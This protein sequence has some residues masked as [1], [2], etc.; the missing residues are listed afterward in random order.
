M[1]EADRA[2]VIRDLIG[3]RPDLPGLLDRERERVKVKRGALAAGGYESMAGDPDLYKYF[4]RRYQ[5]LTRVSGSIGVVLPRGAFINH[6]SRGFRE[7]LFEETTTRRVDF[8]LNKARWAFD[9]E[10][11]YSVALVVAK[12]DEPPQD[13]RVEIAGVAS[14][15]DEWVRQSMTPG[16]CISSAGFGPGWM[17]PLVR[18]QAEADLLAKVR[19]GNLFPFGPRR[20]S[21][22]SLS[23]S[24]CFPVAE[25][26]E[27]ND[28]YLWRRLPGSGVGRDDG[29]PSLDPSGGTDAR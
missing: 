3:K 15:K 18:N 13:H 4:C 10:P 7:W 21:S 12:R 17:T 11:R 28:R 1:P 27:T 26:H 8:L 14:S 23:L 5:Q 9:A 6:G 2:A 19:V 29:P 20:S 16:V 24:L 25:L 22:L